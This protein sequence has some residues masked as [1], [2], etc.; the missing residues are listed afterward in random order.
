MSDDTIRLRIQ[1]DGGPA[2]AARITDVNTGATLEGVFSVSL[3]ASKSLPEA[4]IKVYQPVVD[5]E[6]DATMINVCAACQR[7]IK[8]DSIWYRLQEM[9]GRVFKRGK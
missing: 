8:L 9:I 7:Q 4:V 6:T 5:I 2:H 1:Y 3:D